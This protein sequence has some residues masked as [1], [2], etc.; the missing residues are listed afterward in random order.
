MTGRRKGRFPTPRKRYNRRTWEIYWYWERIQYRVFP[1]F[2]GEADALLVEADLR[3]FAAALASDD[4]VFPDKYADS[5]AVRNYLAVREDTQIHDVRIVT[6][7]TTAYRRATEYLVERR[8]TVE[9]EAERNRRGMS[10]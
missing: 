9:R 5:P 6:E 3:Q 4:T 10:R 8:Q 7:F 2:M 1:G